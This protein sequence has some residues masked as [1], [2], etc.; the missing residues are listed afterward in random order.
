MPRGIT[1]TNTV[2]NPIA[3]QTVIPDATSGVVAPGVVPNS[4]SSLVTQT[5]TNPSIISSP[6]VPDL[7]TSVNVPGLTTTQDDTPTTATPGKFARGLDKLK[8]KDPIS[9][10]PQKVFQDF[11]KITDTFS[12]LVAYVRDIADPVFFNSEYIIFTANKGLR[13][14]YTT[15][16]TLTTQIGYGRELAEVINFADLGI[17][18]N[19]SANYND[20]LTITELLDIA[21]QYIKDIS[22]VE[23]TSIVD[24]EISNSVSSI[25]ADNTTTTDILA[26]LFSAEISADFAYSN[27]ADYA[28][29]L[30]RFLQDY[31]QVATETPITPYKLFTEI[32]TV[33]ETSKRVWSIFREF[34][35]LVIS[36]DDYYG[37][38]NIDDDQYADFNKGVVDLLNINELVDVLPYFAVYINPEDFYSGVDSTSILTNKILNS[39]INSAN[40]ELVELNIGKNV[41]ELKTIS[42]LVNFT[43]NLEKLSPVV[44]LEDLITSLGRVLYSFARPADAPEITLQSLVLNAVS[45]TDILIPEMTFRR[46]LQSISL[47][48]DSNYILDVAKYLV[49]PIYTQSQTSILKS[50]GFED[51]VSNTDDFNRQ[52]DYKRAI[53]DFITTTDDY[54]GTAN[55]DDDQYA[56][57]DK[58]INDDLLIQQRFQKYFTTVKQSA[59]YSTNTPLLELV[60]N[61]Y[62]L[63]KVSDLESAEYFKVSADSLS[64][65]N[66]I[67]IDISKIFEELLSISDPLISQSLFNRSFTDQIVN[68]SSNSILISIPEIDAVTQTSNFSRIVNYIRNIDENKTTSE[69]FTSRSQL[70][71]INQLSIQDAFDR[72]FIRQTGD[73]QLQHSETFRKVVSYVRNI[74]DLIT[75]TDDYY[76]AAN[77]D[78]DQIATVKKRLVDPVDIN[79]LDL[80]ILKNL[81][82]TET[83]AA[84][85][86]NPISLNTTKPL[87]DL[88]QTSRFNYA[89]VFKVLLDS[90]TLSEI[91]YANV[92]TVVNDA[93][94]ATDPYFSISG[95]N[96]V[97]VDRAN[98]TEYI[99]SIATSI[100]KS[101]AVTAQ[102]YYSGVANFYRQVDELK[103]FTDQTVLYFS[104]YYRSEPLSIDDTNAKR[105]NKY[106]DN[107]LVTQ[108][109]ESFTVTDFVRNFQ[110][111]I[112]ATDDYYAQA[113][114]DDDQY[115]DF[116]KS[117]ADNVTIGEAV[118]VLP[119][120]F[121]IY[122]PQEAL[123][124]N[125]DTNSMFI[126]IYPNTETISK[127]EE[128]IIDIN[129][130]I[131]TDTIYNYSQPKS[132]IRHVNDD[133]S[134]TTSEDIVF[135][136]V[137]YIDFLVEIIGS[138]DY[139]YSLE[140]RKVQA[141]TLVLAEYLIKEM[142][143][144]RIIPEIL[145]INSGLE[146]RYIQVNKDLDNTNNYVYLQNND[147]QYLKPNKGLTDQNFVFEDFTTRLTSS[148]GLYDTVTATDDYYGAANIDDDQYATFNKT[149]SDTNTTTDTFKYTAFIQQL[150]AFTL[151]EENK[152]NVGKNVVET[153]HFMETFTYDKF[154]VTLFS[155]QILKSDSGTI[156]NQNYFASTYVAPGYVG[157]NRTIGS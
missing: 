72:R 33:Q 25:Q 70:V 155:D 49:S 10:Q 24:L 157:T 151:S 131:P 117:V 69:L 84:T 53:S 80:F 3:T 95:F 102:D 150:Q 153:L 28:Y 139:E 119:I 135:T 100:I 19:L 31:L 149:L 13:D 15:T 132:F 29:S 52:V 44:T 111:F 73:S 42:E 97:F 76:G 59:I 124:A 144:R 89:D 23:T 58:R 61:Y 57:F 45:T 27:D 12:S 127:F 38:S 114:I 66:P 94:A 156:N 96:R 129:K 107:D 106:P 99:D 75:T 46:L 83:S 101:D 34:S 4:Q 55:I 43:N 41:Q 134:I 17:E 74:Q 32:L 39:N 116:I 9:K 11:N 14:F 48:N 133:D 115:A 37:A 90:A 8:V 85:T 87:S 152:F 40:N 26:K 148:F 79:D 22:G 21:L 125:S 145:S 138:D 136:N 62:E 78:D 126:S 36:T 6:V 47:Q 112:D 2:P 54:Y 154:A 16:D 121:T 1:T 92:N 122:S 67:V 128:R 109:D 98:I 20:T 143:Y 5:T 93:L 110:D 64:I 91:Q 88:L 140:T 137:V 51:S 7:T 146:R 63:K 81:Y 65:N 120:T 113:N 30:L 130:Y 71:K 60:N 77:I 50:T 118:D 18:Y 123:F 105:V 104:K 82:I 142:Y 35:D 108:T 86:L 147:T 141:D 103:T 68:S 56:N